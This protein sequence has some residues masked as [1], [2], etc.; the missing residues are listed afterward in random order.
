MF[1]LIKDNGP[2]SEKKYVFSIENEPNL[3]YDEILN[4]Y[5]RKKNV[6][7]SFEKHKSVINDFD[8]RSGLRKAFEYFTKNKVPQ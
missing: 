8:L 4:V 2:S 6:K 7:K 1:E 5:S 3:R